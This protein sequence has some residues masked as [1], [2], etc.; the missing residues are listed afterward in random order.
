MILPAYSWRALYHVWTS[1]NR[2][3]AVTLNSAQVVKVTTLRNTSCLLSCG[4][5]CSRCG[6]VMYRCEEMRSFASLGQICCRHLELSRC[7]DCPRI[8]P[9]ERMDSLRISSQTGLNTR[10]ELST[11][12]CLE[13]SIFDWWDVQLLSLR[14]DEKLCFSGADMLQTFG[15]LS[16]PG[17]PSHRSGRAHGFLAIPAGYTCYLTKRGQS[18]W[19]ESER[20]FPKGADAWNGD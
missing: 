15:A 8:G 13:L 12:G 9:V 18:T 10:T 11:L 1:Q 3:E 16:L 5:M 19:T 20:F 14:R 6:Q 4:H 2:L 7:L 17:L